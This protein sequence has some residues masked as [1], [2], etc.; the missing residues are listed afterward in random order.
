MI[1]QERYENDTI[2]EIDLELC[3]FEKRHTDRIW[4]FSSGNLC[5]IDNLPYLIHVTKG[6]WLTSANW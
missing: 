1:V 2:R 4:D 3:G 6:R 5:P